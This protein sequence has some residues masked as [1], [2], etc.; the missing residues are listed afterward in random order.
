MYDR[1]LELGETAYR[2]DKVVREDGHPSGMGHGIGLPRGN[3]D[4]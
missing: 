1:V 4:S 3:A 2:Q